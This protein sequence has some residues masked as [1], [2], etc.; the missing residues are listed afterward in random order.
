MVLPPQ[1]IS[2]IAY[3]GFLKNQPVYLM[4]SV[5]TGAASFLLLPLYTRSFSPD[6]FG[7]WTLF[8]LATQVF[9]VVLTWGLDSAAIR[10]W[11]SESDVEAQRASMSEVLSLAL[12]IAT[13]GAGLGVGL[14]WL[15]ERSWE[16]SAFRDFIQL[17]PLIA[18]T[19]SALGVGMGLIRAQ[20]RAWVFGQISLARVGTQVSASLVAAFLGRLSLPVA[21][22][23]W[24]AGDVAGLL[25]VLI[26][27]R[28]R[29]GVTGDLARKSLRYGFPMLL[30]G[31]GNFLLFGADRYLLASYRTL[32][33]VAV[34]SLAYK[35]STSLEVAVIR[36]FAVSWAAGRFSMGSGEGG[37]ENYVR[38]LALFLVPSV[39]VLAAVSCLRREI[40]SLVAPR[41]YEGAVFLVPILLLAYLVLG[42]S[43]PLNVGVMFRDRPTPVATATW[44]AVLV[45]MLGNLILI[46]IWGA[47]GASVATLAGYSVLTLLLWRDSIAT[48]PINYPWG[49]L[50]GFTGFGCGIGFV[51]SHVG[52]G[53]IGVGSLIRLSVV[54]A[55]I[56]GL[57]WQLGLL[58]LAAGGNLVA[59][60]AGG[61]SPGS[62]K[63]FPG[64]RP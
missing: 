12:W 33:E 59:V 4:A 39:L 28:P 26:V 42:L 29:L 60:L 6:D 10:K 46:P 31:I 37:K 47:T 63:V 14:L 56:A 53:V 30:G 58:R 23:A 34:Y 32:Q 9:S 1:E 25:L 7:R 49:R 55:S 3:K 21:S 50:I 2:R 57:A 40:I 54:L 16:E 61:S 51:A 44:M 64:E 5:A 52:S 35:L 19:E 18:A 43:Y 22:V 41:G 8:L 20:N 45:N 11:H 62:G 24:L 48:H 13:L 36:P 27:L 15:T 38:A 17:G